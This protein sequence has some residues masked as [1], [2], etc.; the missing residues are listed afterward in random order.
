MAERTFKVAES[1]QVAYKERLYSAGESIVVD[2][3]D[4]LEAESWLRN[5][6]VKEEK[7]GRGGVLSKAQPTVRPSKA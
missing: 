5:G 6:Y 4:F 3:E 7:A 1:T 2:E